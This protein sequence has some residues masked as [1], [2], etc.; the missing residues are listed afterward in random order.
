[1]LGNFVEN[2][3]F[4]VQD[5]VQGYYW[6]SSQCTLH[7]IMIYHKTNTK[8][9]SHSL[10]YL[11]DDL[12][13]DVNMVYEILKQ[14]VHFIQNFIC[15]NVSTVHYFSDGCA[16]QYKNCKNFLNLCFHQQ[17]F[18]VKCTWSFFARWHRQ[19]LQSKFAETTA[20]SNIESPTNVWVLSRRDN[21]YHN[22]IYCQ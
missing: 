17:D 2:Y 8:L 15:D 14:T 5:E 21:R 1:M 13:H 18:G 3:V 9:Q 4:V 19:N 7:P 22:D 12:T 10:C 6:N 20:Q 16:A 11:S